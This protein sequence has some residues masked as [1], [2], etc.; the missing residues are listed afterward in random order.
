MMQTLRRNAQKGHRQ[1]LYIA[2]KELRSTGY[3]NK[4]E[5]YWVDAGF[6]FLLVIGCNSVQNHYGYLDDFSS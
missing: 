1:F 4:W 5:K 6:V 3:K 2:H